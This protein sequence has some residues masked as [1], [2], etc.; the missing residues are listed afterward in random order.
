MMLKTIFDEVMER[1]THQLIELV[2]D[3]L[4][5]SG[6]VLDIGSGTGHVSAWLE[7]ELA[8]DVTPAD[9]TDMHVVGPAPAI[10][11]DG[12]LPFESGQFSAA[13]LFFMLHYPH[14]PVGL[15]AEAARVSRG[16]V[17]VVQS[18]YA[19]R[20]GYAWLRGRE[21]IWTSV[22]FYVSKIIGYVPADAQFTMSARRFHTVASL[23][24]DV[25]AAGLRVR[26][27]RER[28]VLARNAL[29]VA[30]W[31]LEPDD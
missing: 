19:G 26:S 14:N 6:T 29:T 8:I 10:I 20:V 18:L 30:A 11:P 5:E 21:F 1:R 3:W 17:I 24:R 16:P 27:T 22:A 31:L 23:E 9:V 7:R 28:P 2:R 15:L 25:R 12:I 4:P 13:L